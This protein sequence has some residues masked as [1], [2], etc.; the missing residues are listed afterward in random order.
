MEPC[1]AVN[2][3]LPLRRQPRLPCSLLCTKMPPYVMQVATFYLAA[4]TKLACHDPC[5][6]SWATKLKFLRG[7]VADAAGVVVVV[8]ALVLLLTLCL[9]LHAQIQ[10]W[11]TD[12]RKYNDN[13]LASPERRTSTL[14]KGAARIRTFETLPN[15]LLTVGVVLKDP[16]RSSRCSHSAII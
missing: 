16:Q 2:P 14:N 8:V 1:E 12:H 4:C 11:E 15:P 7:V 9:F 6:P 5:H 10:V 3:P 13:M